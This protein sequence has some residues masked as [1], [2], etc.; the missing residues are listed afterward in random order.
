M[1]HLD[2]DPRWP[3]WLRIFYNVGTWLITLIIVGAIA[4]FVFAP[5]A[6]QWVGDPLRHL[7]GS[8]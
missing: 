3:L 7:L 8:Q 4:R 5:L 6:H 2:A 1:S